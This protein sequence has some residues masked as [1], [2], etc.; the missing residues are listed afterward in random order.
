MTGEKLVVAAPAMSPAS[1]RASVQTHV[2]TPPAEPGPK[3]AKPNGKKLPDG[4]PEMIEV[5]VGGRTARWEQA[6]VVGVVAGKLICQLVGGQRLKTPVSG[7][8]I[9]W[10]V[11]L[12]V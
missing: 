9:S 7:H 1:D 6:Q 12:A 10:R 3:A 4:I 8:D 11:P 5:D 2:T